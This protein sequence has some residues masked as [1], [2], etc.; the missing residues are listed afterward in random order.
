MRTREFPAL[1]R[2]SPKRWSNRVKKYVMLAAIPVLLALGLFL[3][4]P[5]QAALAAATNRQLPI[6]CVE[7]TDNICSLT[8]DAAWGDVNLR[9]AV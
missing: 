1:R 6:Y 3:T 5:G 8:F 7:K 9:H 4:S 2:L